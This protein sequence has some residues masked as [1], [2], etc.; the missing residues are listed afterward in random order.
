[1]Y[2]FKI[3]K[4]STILLIVIINLSFIINACRHDCIT[5]D[6]S[7]Y[8][9]IYFTND[10]LPIFQTNCAVT[11]CHDGGSGSKKLTLNSYDNIIKEV[12]KGNPQ[13]SRI[14]TAI[15]GTYGG[16]MPPSYPLTESQRT[17]IR[18]WIVEGAFNNS[19]PDTTA[20]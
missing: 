4:E 9:T 15:I 6:N 3:K 19:K 11:G 10:V 16:N 7:T 17:M 5:I 12:Q 14:Y 18:L 20:K 8:P 13:R 2:K 1:M